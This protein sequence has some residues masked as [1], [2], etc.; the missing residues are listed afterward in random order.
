MIYEDERAKPLEFQSPP[1]KRVLF[2]SR[3]GSCL[4]ASV[5]LIRAGYPGINIRANKRE[6]YLKALF[7]V[8]HRPL[9]DQT[10][11]KLFQGINYT[12]STTSHGCTCIFNAWLHWIYTIRGGNIWFRTVVRT[13]THQN[14]TEVRS[15]V[16]VQ[17]Q[18]D[19]LVVIRTG[20]NPN[21]PLVFQANIYCVW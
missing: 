18:T 14:L 5:P 11:W 12:G 10:T 4:L 21:E 7:T 3:H 19:G 16:R 20:S 8:S 9:N 13:W 15:K 17:N 1:T 2:W 6:D